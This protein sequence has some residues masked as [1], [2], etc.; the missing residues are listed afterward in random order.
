MEVLLVLLEACRGLGVAEEGL[1]AVFGAGLLHA[2]E[3]WG[4]V[5]PPKRR[6]ARLRR[7]WVWLP[8]ALS[9]QVYPVGEEGAVRIYGDAQ[10]EAAQAEAAQAEAAQAGMGE[11]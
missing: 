6:P 9:P 7:V 11:R 5:V 2:L 8:D 3:T 1:A 4:D 10:T